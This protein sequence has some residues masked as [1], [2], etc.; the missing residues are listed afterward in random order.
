MQICD[1]ATGQS[2]VFHADHHDTEA[3]AILQMAVEQTNARVSI[4]K[5]LAAKAQVIT[6]QSSKRENS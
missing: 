4:A 1:N 6:S 3:N 5:R 2:I